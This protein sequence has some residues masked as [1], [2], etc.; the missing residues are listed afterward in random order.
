M[1][2]NLLPKVEVD[3]VVS[4]VDPALVIAAAEKAIYTGHKGDGKIFVSSVND[5]FRVRTGES[6]Q[7]AV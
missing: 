1:N 7:A 6:G 5:V 4:E 2:V 3:I